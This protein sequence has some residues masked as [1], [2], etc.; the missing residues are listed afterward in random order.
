MTT[1]YVF[2]PE[3]LI[4]AYSLGV[5]PMASSKDDP[6]I[7]FYEP[8]IRGILP[9][10]PPHIPRRLMRLVKQRPYK[11]TYNTAFPAVITACA[12]ITSTRDDSW[13]NPEIERLYIALHAMGFA[14]SVEVW[15][16]VQLI[17]GLYGVKIG[18]AFFGESMFSRAPNTSKIALA[19]LMGRLHLTGFGLLDAQ[20]ANDHLLQFGLIEVPRDD[21][22]VILQS[23]LQDS[24]DL[25]LDIKEDE[26]IDHL[27]HLN[28]VT[29]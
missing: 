21:F 25:R 17:G 6:D 4:K 19:H 8:D 13:I 22:Q 10:M 7:H 16:D 24:C 28:K 5:F 14:H 1:S 15:D 2:S 20:F 23:A 3:T 18:G 9:I 27:L 29:S 26:I 12:E 11:V